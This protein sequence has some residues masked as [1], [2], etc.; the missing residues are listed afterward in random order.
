[1]FIAYIRLQDKRNIDADIIIY[2]VLFHVYF[3]TLCFNNEIVF[4][5]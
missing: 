4:N 5:T 2:I 1:M 3:E